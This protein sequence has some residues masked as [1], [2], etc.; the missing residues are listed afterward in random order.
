[1]KRRYL[2]P[3]ACLL[4]AIVTVALSGCFPN[5]TAAAQQQQVE[6][7]T[8][9]SYSPDGLRIAFIST[10]GGATPQIFVANA[11]GSGVRQLTEG[12]SNASPAWSPDGR[13]IIFSSNRGKKNEGDYD[14]WVMNAD[15]SNPQH[16]DLQ[17]PAAQ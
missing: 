17:M 2:V 11:D 4:A 10:K 6:L 9:A 7:Y 12:S 8:Q 3:A 13:K 1:M 5:L 16:I 15:G 14:L